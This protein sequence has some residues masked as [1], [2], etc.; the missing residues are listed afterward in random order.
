MGLLV[1]LVIWSALNVVLGL[2]D[3]SLFQ[4]IG[5]HRLSTLLCFVLIVTAAGV[6]NHLTLFRHHQYRTYFRRFEA[7]DRNSRIRIHFISALVILFILAV[8]AFS[9]GFLPE[10]HAR[11]APP[12][13]DDGI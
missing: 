8:F 11:G 13:A 4:I 9:L 1:A 6:F 10:L 7:L 3:K 12:R 5:P 2:Q